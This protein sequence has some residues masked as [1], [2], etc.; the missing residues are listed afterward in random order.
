VPY[1]TYFAQNEV[2]NYLLGPAVVA[3]AFPLYQQIGLI[4]SKWK[5][6]L[7]SC[8]VGSVLSM[9]FGTAIA[10]SMGADAQLA[11]SILP[12]SV[13]TPIAMAVSHQ[14]GGIPA[15]TAVMV[16]MAG[17][18]GSVVG[19][20]LLKLL[21]IRPSIAKGLT[22]G[23]VSHALGTAKAAEEN[24]QEGAF[25]SLALVIC[26]VFTSILAPFILP[27]VFHTFG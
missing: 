5:T 1:Q 26:G 21:R 12:K 16:I 15:I 2:I 14:I 17:L 24:F 4:R 19:Y 10:F 22:M 11:A 3:L 7:T 27:L 20:P 25:S 13:T 23:T 9:T 6:I 18:F 8:F